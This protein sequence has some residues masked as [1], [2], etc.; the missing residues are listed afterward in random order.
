VLVLHR[1]DPLRR[2]HQADE[3]DLGGA[4][5]LEVAERVNRAAP[6]GEHRVEHVHTGLR[7]PGRQSLVVADRHVLLLVAV[8]ADVPD[9]GVG[10]QAQEALD[11]PEAGAQNGHDRHLV[12]QAQARRGFER[13]LDLDRLERQLARDLDRHDRR[14]LEQRLTERAVRRVAVAQHRQAI[15]QHRVLDHSQRL[16][17]GAMLSAR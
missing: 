5:A 8:D 15:G 3:L 17:H 2:R 13:G 4:G 7:E 11:H 16:W 12:A 6:G 10:Q 14:G 9:P 1:L